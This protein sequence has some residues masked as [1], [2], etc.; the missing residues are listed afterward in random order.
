MIKWRPL[1]I[2]GAS[3]MLF[4]TAGTAKA[5]TGFQD[6]QTSTVMT[7]PTEGTPLTFQERMA[8]IRELLAQLPD[9]S[10]VPPES[11]AY[12]RGL[13]AY[14]QGNYALAETAFREAAQLRPTVS[15]YHYALGVALHGQQRY[16]DAETAFRVALREDSNVAA[17]HYALGCALVSQEKLP[18]AAPAFRE[19]QRI[20]PS[21]T[22]EAEFT[23]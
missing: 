19:A 9:L 10:Q 15:G 14:N 6:T 3:A 16:T 1:L 11:Q 22:T 23:R 20:D 2:M 8:R 4:S 7:Q 12:E 18:D 5:C 21:M 17:Y 13:I